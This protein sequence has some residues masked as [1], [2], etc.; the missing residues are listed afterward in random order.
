MQ[1][2]MA[3]SKKKKKKS[4]FLGVGQTQLE[5]YK[6][7]AKKNQESSTMNQGK[8]K[9]QFQDT[10][11][12]VSEDTE[13]GYNSDNSDSRIFKTFKRGNNKSKPKVFC[14]QS[15]QEL[16]EIAELDS[17]SKAISSNNIISEIISTMQKHVI[18]DDIM[19]LKQLNDNIIY[20]KKQYLLQAQ[21]FQSEKDFRASAIGQNMEYNLKIHIGRLN[22]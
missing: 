7:L 14:T 13:N 3:K 15:L 6:E 12:S 11:N 22:Q 10:E 8:L 16:E 21:G 17:N 4:M 1:I 19:F 2:D 20:H 5:Y 18:N 9:I